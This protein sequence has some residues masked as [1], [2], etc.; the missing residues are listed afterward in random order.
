ME[1]HR[2]ATPAAFIQA[3]AATFKDLVQKLTGPPAG[4]THKLRPKSAMPFKLRERRKQSLSDLE[5]IAKSPG[6]SPVNAPITPLGCES[7]VWDRVSTESPPSVEEK[8]IAE[9]GF[10]LHASPAK[11]GPPVLLTL[12]PLTP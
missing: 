10:Y 8:A 6:N 5:I 9:K 1:K 3:D 11:A 2:R 4:S 12:F 7:V